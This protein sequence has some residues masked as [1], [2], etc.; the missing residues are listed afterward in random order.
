[1]FG[2]YCVPQGL[3][4]PRSPNFGTPAY[5][6]IGYSLKRRVAASDPDE[7]LPSWLL[8][9]PNTGAGGYQFSIMI[10]DPGGHQVWD[11][12]FTF[13]ARAR[14]AEAH[15]AVMTLQR[16]LLIPVLRITDCH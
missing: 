8:L 11:H 15:E 2:L 14:C 9:D 13:P 12:T 5:A 6:P 16:K 4:G 1:M 7:C 3:G 10:D